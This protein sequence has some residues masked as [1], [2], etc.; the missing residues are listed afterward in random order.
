MGV[1]VRLSHLCPAFLIGT[2]AGFRGIVLR[3]SPE[4]SL[5]CSREKYMTHSSEGSADYRRDFSHLGEELSRLLGHLFCHRAQRPRPEHSWS[6][7]EMGC[8]QHLRTCGQVAEGSR[9]GSSQPAAH[10]LPE[11]D[12]HDI[13]VRSTCPGLGGDDACPLDWLYRTS[14]SLP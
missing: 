14:I 12:A 2:F 10:H 13:E 9:L 4:L 5:N 3:R 7:A 8:A 6:S 11:A 1:C